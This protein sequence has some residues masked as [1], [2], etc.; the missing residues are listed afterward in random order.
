MFDT[1]TWHII[2][3]VSTVALLALLLAWETLAPAVGGPQRWRHALRNLSLALLNTLLL[4]LVFAAAIA[5]VAHWTH[6][7]KVGL[8]N[9]IEMPGWA[10]LLSALLLLDLWLYLWHRAN[11]AIPLLWRFHQVHHA[12]ERLDVTTATRFHPGELVLAAS[13][14][15]VLIPLLGLQLR[16]LLIHDTLVIVAT[17]FHHADISLGRADRV[18]RWLIVTPGMHSVH[19]SPRRDEYDS[20]FGVVL[21]LWDRLAGTLCD[22]ARR[23]GVFGLPDAP[24]DT[25]A[26]ILRTPFTS[27]RTESSCPPTDSSRANPAR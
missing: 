26:G 2:K 13:L 1:E 23:P 12:D 5:F 27:G 16:D 20:N 3:S 14:R 17:Q 4:A 10:R 7:N 6:D 22:H 18:L 15:L 11:H 24:P 19:H 9:L 25:F 21:S 8:L